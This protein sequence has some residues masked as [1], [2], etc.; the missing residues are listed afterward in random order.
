LFSQELESLQK[1]LEPT[2]N[3]IQRLVKM[4]ATAKDDELEQINL[5]LLDARKT[6]AEMRARLFVL[7][8]AKNTIWQRLT[9][10]PG[11]K[12]GTQTWPRCWKKMQKRRE[13]QERER[14]SKFTLSRYQERAPD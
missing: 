13:A 7:Q 2:Q 6:D 11:G 10:C 14:K 4:G 3:M 12:Q 8:V 9:R 5:C 1:A